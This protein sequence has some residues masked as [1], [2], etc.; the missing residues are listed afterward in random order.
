MTGLD[1]LDL[2]C[3]PYMPLHHHGN[4]CGILHHQHIGTGLVGGVIEIGDGEGS[5]ENLSQFH[6]TVPDF[7]SIPICGDDGAI[8]SPF[9]VGD[10]GGWNGGGEGDSGSKSGIDSSV[11]RSHLWC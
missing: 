11:I 1:Q 8:E 7:N 6:A 4:P 9:H 2:T 3:L 5:V 10:S